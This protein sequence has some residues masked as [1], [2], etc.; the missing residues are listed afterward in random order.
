MAKILIVEDDEDLGSDLALW[1]TSENHAV[2]RITNGSAA[3][4]PILSGLYQVVILDWELPG[5][6]GPEILKRCKDAG[7][8]VPVIMLTGRDALSDKLNGLD[9]GA[10]DYLTKPFVASELSARIRAVLRRTEAQSSAES[11]A[12]NH[13]VG[14]IQ[15]DPLSFQA[16]CAGQALLLTPLEYK[17]LLLLIENHNQRITTGESLIE[18]VWRDNWSHAERGNLDAVRTCISQLRKKIAIAGADVEITA[19]KSGGYKLTEIP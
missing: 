12:G 6:N 11:W 9:S 1:L 17:C 13:V 16:T 14:N 19:V 7:C 3:V 5:M 18:E 15:L 4:H 10:F 8:T 2:D